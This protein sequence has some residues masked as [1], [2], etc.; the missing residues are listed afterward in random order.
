MD[1]K[2]KRKVRN[3]VSGIVLSV[4]VLLVLAYCGVFEGAQS[5][6]AQVR[7]L[8]E[9]SREE[10]NDKDWQDLFDLCD[11]TEAEKQA[12]IEAVPAQADIVQLDSVAAAEIISIPDGATEYELDVTVTGHIGK[13]FVK[14]PQLNSVSCHVCFVKK[15]GRW[16]IDINNPKANFG[17]YVQKPTM[18]K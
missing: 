9:H 7:S 17:P 11:L 10:I 12:W 8:L 15:N 14:G 4:L 16:Y 13:L 5:D 1:D 2:Q 18:P 3:I 6:E